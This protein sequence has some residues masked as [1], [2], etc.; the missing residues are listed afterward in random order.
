MILKN[1]MM[2]Y[3]I[4]TVNK[5]HFYNFIHSEITNVK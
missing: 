4:N 2:I 1:T 3:T 5:I